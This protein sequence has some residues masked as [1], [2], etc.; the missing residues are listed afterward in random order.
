[1]DWECG[2][3]VEE[4]KCIQGF[5]C[6]P[7][8]KESLGRFRLKWENNIFIFLQETLWFVDWIN[9]AHSRVE[10]HKMQENS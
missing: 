8:W 2:P 5:G 7:E 4:G 1:L 6:K 3:Y 10:F 9:L